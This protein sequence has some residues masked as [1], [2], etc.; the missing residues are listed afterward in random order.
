MRKAIIGNEG[1]DWSSTY[2]NSFKNCVLSAYEV[3]GLQQRPRHKISAL[4]ESYKLIG[5]TRMW[6]YSEN[7]KA[8]L[9]G[10]LFARVFPRDL[11]FN[12]Y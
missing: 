5:E 7:K 3:L 9:Q 12:L 1:S 4:G 6:I 2:L 10:I 8:K 11:V